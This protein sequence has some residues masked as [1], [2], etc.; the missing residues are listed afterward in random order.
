MLGSCGRA[1]VFLKLS[2]SSIA[3][4]FMAIHLGDTMR[5]KKRRRL[6]LKQ[7]KF[8]GEYVKEGNATKAVRMAYPNIQTEGAQR[9]MASKLVANGNVQAQIQAIMEEEGLTPELVIRSLKELVTDEDKS[10]RVKAVRIACEV[11]GMIGARGVYQQFNLG[12][13]HPSNYKDIAPMTPE[14]RWQ[15]LRRLLEE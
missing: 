7:T 15:R 11:M 6:T 14:E 1:R 4:S 8:V 9:V 10:V 12:N 3:N 13:E 5:G 2:R